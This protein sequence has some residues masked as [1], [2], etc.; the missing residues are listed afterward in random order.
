MK[1]HLGCTIESQ[2]GLPKYFGHEFDCNGYDRDGC[3]TNWQRAL[4][5]YIDRYSPTLKGNK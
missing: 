2:R 4:I 1:E 5:K 3:R